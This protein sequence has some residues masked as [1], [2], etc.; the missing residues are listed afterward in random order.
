MPLAMPM[1]R[2]PRCLAT[3]PAMEP[4]APAAAEMTRVSPAFAFSTS[5][6]PK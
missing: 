1:T 3:W 2:Q 6:T 5:V 4:T